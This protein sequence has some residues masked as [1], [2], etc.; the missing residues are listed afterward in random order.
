MNDAGLIPLDIP[1]QWVRPSDAMPMDIGLYFAY[2]HKYGRTLDLF[3]GVEWYWHKSDGK[4]GAKMGLP[5]CYLYV[6]PEPLEYIQEGC[7]HEWEAKLSGAPGDF[8][9][10]IA[11]CKHCGK[12]Y[13]DG[14]L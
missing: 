10:Y 4:R 12:V 8:I 3:D 13:E 5:V 14:D 9:E 2:Y 1:S 7:P 11:V 6:A